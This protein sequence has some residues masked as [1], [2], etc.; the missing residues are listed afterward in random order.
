MLHHSLTKDGATVS[1]PAIRRY[2][3]ETMGWKDV[4]YH[5]G[6]E[7]AG[8]HYEALVGRSLF[9]DGAHCKQ[10]E[11]N[12]K[13]IGICLVGN[14]DKAT[15]PAAQMEVLRDRLLLPL[16]RGFDIPPSKIVFHRE[17]ASY[18]SCPGTMLTKTYLAQFV[19]GVVV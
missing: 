13:A 18:K 8:S 7:L 6:V 1:W 11:M 9:E 12:R 2:H 10:G 16:M 15:P 3:K 14:F 17:Y 19:P 5:L 4:G